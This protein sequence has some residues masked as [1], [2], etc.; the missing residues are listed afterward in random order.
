MFHP[1]SGTPLDELFTRYMYYERAKLGIKSSTTEAL[2]KFYER[3]T[4]A[5]FK[6]EETLQNLMTLA[7]FWQD[8]NLQDSER[9]SQDS[10]KKLF[11]LNYAPNGM[12]TYLVS[13]YFMQN[14]DAEGNLDDKK[15][16]EFLDRITAFIWGYALTNPGVNSLRTPVFAAMINIV[17]NQDVTCLLYTSD[18]ADE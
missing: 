6:R 8:V 16:N 10:L 18:A 5:I 11:V 12:W 17:N 9:F 7:K 3:D 1:I 13:V 15:F 4:Y 2:K 14:K